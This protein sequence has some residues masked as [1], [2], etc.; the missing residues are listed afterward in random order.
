[1]VFNKKKKCIVCHEVIVSKDLIK[2]FG[3]NFCSQKCLGQYKSLLEEAKKT[4]L[5]NCC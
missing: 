5:D 4:K 1:M 3:S 2:E